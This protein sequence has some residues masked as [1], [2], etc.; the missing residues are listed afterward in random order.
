MTREDVYDWFRVNKCEVEPL[1]DDLRG[2][3]VKI[4]NP[5]T[6]RY[7][8]FI[9]PINDKPV[10]DYSVCKMCCQLGVPIP[11]ECVHM[12]PLTEFIKSKHYP[13]F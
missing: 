1:A 12:A 5:K 9:T 13:D 10:N 7:I 3:S 8:Y 4:I 6:K 11:D 2:N